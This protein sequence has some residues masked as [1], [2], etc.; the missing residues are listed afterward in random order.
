MEEHWFNT[1]YVCL[2]YAI[3][4]CRKACKCSMVV[5]SRVSAVC[6]ARQR[7]CNVHRR[8]W[9]S[10]CCFTKALGSWRFMRNLS[11][12]H[13]WTKGPKDQ[14]FVCLIIV[15]GGLPLFAHFPM[16][17]PW[18]PPFMARTWQI[19]GDKGDWFGVVWDWYDCLMIP[20]VSY[21]RFQSS[22]NVWK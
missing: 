21:S 22:S 9:E 6:Q 8:G 15:F 5:A 10:S 17:F 14:R 12:I 2:D 18:K 13:G 16:V 4:V 11:L 20:S 1:A 7:R 19:C 3:K